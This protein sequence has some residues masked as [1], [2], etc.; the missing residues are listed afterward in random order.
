MRRSAG[1]AGNRRGASGPRN[2][3][4][5]SASVTH[6]LALGI[7]AI[8]ISGLLFTAGTLLQE[9]RQD[10]A[11]EQLLTVGNRMADDLTR[12]AALAQD[13]GNVSFQTKHPTSVAGRSYTVQFLTG[14]DCDTDLFDVEACLELTLQDQ[15][16]VVKVPVRNETDVSF[17]RMSNGRYA[18]S[19]VANATAPAP[20]YPGA[21]T[22]LRVGI[23]ESI[24]QFSAGKAVDASNKNPISGF[25]FS[26]GQPSNQTVVHFQNDT[27]DLDGVISKYEWDFDGDGVAD[28]EG[29]EVYHNFARPGK[30]TVTLTV[31]DDD[32]GTD[33]VSKVVSV[34]GLAFEDVSAEN[35]SGS[36][37][38]GAIHFDVTNL[39]GAPIEINSLLVDPVSGTPD[40]LDA[41]GSTKPEIQIDGDNRVGEYYGEHP[42]YEDGRIY[43]ISSNHA[44]LS[45]G[46]R[47]DVELNGFRDSSSGDTLDMTTEPVDVV[48]RYEVE[49]QYYTSKFRLDPPGGDSDDEPPEP[50]FT[51]D[52]N[53]APTCSFTDSSS[54]PDNNVVDYHWSFGD[55]ETSS[56]KDPTHDFDRNGTYTV[57]LTVTNDAT[58]TE[59][60]TLKRTI[61][62]GTARPVLVF[63]VNAGGP[64][65]E[66][67]GV[68]YEADEFGD[69]HRFLFRDGASEFE[70]VGSGDPI[71][72]VSG[73]E[74]ELYRTARSAEDGWWIFVDPG[75]FGYE[76]PVPNGEYA[77]TFKFAELDS[78]VGSGEREINVEL[79]GSDVLNQYDVYDQ[80]GGNHQFAVYR[81]ET[82]PVDD[83]NL[84]IELKPDSNVEAPTLSSVVV[85]QE[86]ADSFQGS[87][88][89]V[90][91]EAEKRMRVVP[92]SDPPGP[93]N[94]YSEV[95]WNS[96]TDGSANGSKALRAGEGSWANTGDSEDG[97]RLDYYVDFDETGT[98]NV[99]VRMRCPDNSSRSVHVGLD[100]VPVTYGGNGMNGNSTEL[101]TPNSGWMWASQ[102]AGSPVQVDVDSTGPHT[103][104]VW[105]RQD[106]V[107]ID[108]VVLAKEGNY[109]TY[110]PTD[111]GQ[112]GPD[113]SAIAP[114]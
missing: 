5:I 10:S 99:W 7:T 8:L 60:S 97:E 72:N 36:V 90:A 87:S 91:M 64:A 70:S 21:H 4:A 112:T 30:Y 114:P 49:G 105:M 24:D 65:M 18:I 16:T 113:D 6:A 3:R 89:K 98:Y 35:V 48:I 17:E 96:F 14:G 20:T 94:D 102:A 63:A 22:D 104:N 31:T 69:P 79:E 67:D 26:P 37:E 45:S 108:K 57:S 103:L 2:D 58:P 39:H 109:P 52:C 50:R 29:R 92:G 41:S 77:V 111:D 1:P 32:G 11:R 100:G 38:D 51:V 95:H 33:S 71:Y 42:L 9:Q 84:T 86:W 62:V 85:R 74:K 13:G 28:R 101:C 68:N 15:Q 76:V 46:D 106:G 34:G 93:N 27:K 54:D 107:E 19:A 47:A 75:S 55:G 83:G 56:A 44:N 43:D 61:T 88:G 66:I 82:V 12:A 81:T 25:T 110:H 80:A 53:N 23:G 59:S 40:R 78:T 73:A